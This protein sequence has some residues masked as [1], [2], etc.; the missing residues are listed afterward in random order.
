MCGNDG[1][2]DENEI[3][4]A[5]A[6]D[7]RECWQGEGWYRVTDG[8]GEEWEP[9]F[10]VARECL[11]ADMRDAYDQARVCVPCVEPVPDPSLRRAR[12]L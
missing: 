6:G 12:S 11:V 1:Y 5:V 3:E 8:Y 2:M 9:D 10:Y 7:L 4:R